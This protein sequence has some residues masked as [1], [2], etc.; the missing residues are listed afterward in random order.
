MES[1]SS[2]EPIRTTVNIIIFDENFLMNSFFT[3]VTGC[4]PP[5]PKFKKKLKRPEFTGFNFKFQQLG[6]ACS[7]CTL[8][9]FGATLKVGGAHNGSGARTSAH[10]GREGGGCGRGHPPPTVGKN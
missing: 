1:T 9:G 7:V 8:I 3:V 6:I 10:C 2:S 5:L 4:L